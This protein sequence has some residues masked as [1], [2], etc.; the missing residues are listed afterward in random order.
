MVAGHTFCS[1]C[2]VH[3]LR[4]PDSYSDHVEINTD[5]LDDNQVNVQ[6]QTQLVD[7]DWSLSELKNSAPTT[8]SMR[9]NILSFDVSRDGDKEFHHKDTEEEHNM[10]WPHA[11]ATLGESSSHPPDPRSAF[12][13]CHSRDFSYTLQNLTN[14]NTYVSDRGKASTPTTSASTHLNGDSFSRSGASFIEDDYFQDE[15]DQAAS[16]APSLNSMLTSPLSVG[17][18][19]AS[20]WSHS[21]NKIQPFQLSPLPVDDMSVKDFASPIPPPSI[22]MKDQLQHYLK[23]HMTPPGKASTEGKKKQKNTKDLM[24][25]VPKLPT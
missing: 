7:D 10:A 24:Q 14:Q 1:R 20:T 19:S 11:L 6:I 12:V 2:G 17:M 21:T 18:Q 3:I 15:M 13:K 5:C 9:N 8:H 16:I 25:T 22:R 23:K 4:A